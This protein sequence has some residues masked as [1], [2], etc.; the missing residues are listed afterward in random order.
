MS[1]HKAL[2]VGINAY[3]CKP[4]RGCVNDVMQ[5]KAVLQR[6]FGFQEEHFRILLD[7]EATAANIESGLQWLAQDGHEP[8]AIRVFHYSGHGAY[9]PDQNG[10]EPDGRDECLVPYD[11]Q[12]AGKLTDDALKALYNLFPPTANLT[13]VMD[14]CHSGSVNRAP[15]EDIIFRFLPTSSEDL[16][17]IDAAAALFMEAQEEYIVRRLRDE[18]LDEMSDDELRKKVHALTKS[19]RKKRFGDLRTREANI[20]L[21]GCRPEQLCA[22]APIGGD[23]HGAFTYYFCESIVEADG[24]I[25]YQQLAEETGKRLYDRGFLQVPQLE[26]RGKRDHQSAFQPFV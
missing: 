11:Y 12:T 2:L 19:Y 3:P 1:L 6:Y 10:D 20:L 9:T 4:L 26:Y 24:Q 18:R 21:A 17:E 16:R 8:N 13:L 23:Y 15:E 14:S 7:V 22:D 25:T 5:V